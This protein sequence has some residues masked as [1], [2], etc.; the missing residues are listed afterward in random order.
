MKKFKLIFYPIYVLAMLVVL[1]YS[2]DILANMDAYK[3]KVPIHMVFKDIPVYAL[4]IY[5][6]LSL[7]MVVELVAENLHIIKL[8]K[9]AETAEKE[10]L[11]LKAKLYDESTSALSAP[12]EE[13]ETEEDQDDNNDDPEG[14]V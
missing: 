10:V 1:Y 4:S 6:L 9:R 7:I 12:A 11:T 2:I 14:Y 5:I 8:K 3:E 13:E